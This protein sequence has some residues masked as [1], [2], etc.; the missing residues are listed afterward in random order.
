MEQREGW[1]LTQP[2]P[3]IMTWQ[4]PSGRHYTTAPA[5]YLG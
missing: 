2:Q 4:A 1:T 3:G 5:E